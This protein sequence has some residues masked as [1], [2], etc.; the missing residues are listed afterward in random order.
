LAGVD[1]QA[2]VSLYLALIVQHPYVLVSKLFAALRVPYALNDPP[3]AC[4]AYS[5][6][7]PLTVVTA[8]ILA[9]FELHVFAKGVIVGDA[10]KMTTLTV[11]LTPHVP[12][13]AVPAAVEPHAAVMTYLA[14]TV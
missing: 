6:V 3:G 12:L 5:A 7:N 2:A 14:V 9:S 10:G 1:P 4:T 8:L 13:P 11:L